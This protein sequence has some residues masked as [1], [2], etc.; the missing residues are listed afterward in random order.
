MLE[1]QGNGD[2]YLPL[3]D[4][5][6]ALL[7]HDGLSPLSNGTVKVKIGTNKTVKFRI[8]TNET[9]KIRIGTQ[10]PVKARFWPWLHSE[11]P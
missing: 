10:K 11:Y 9:V 6:A 1:N 3:H 7:Q 8:C 5:R 2:R 4:V